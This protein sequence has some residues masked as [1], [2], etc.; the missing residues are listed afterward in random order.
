MYMN[1]LS[2]MTIASHVQQVVLVM[3]EDVNPEIQRAGERVD[4]TGR[5]ELASFGA[6]SGLRHSRELAL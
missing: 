5:F 6:L 1:L 3:K 2:S 4:E